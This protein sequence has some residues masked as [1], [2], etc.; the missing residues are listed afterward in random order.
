M[1]KLRFM[2]MIFN[3]ADGSLVMH[4]K[5]FIQPAF[6]RLGITRLKLEQFDSLNKFII[7]YY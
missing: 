1:K 6:E 5:C 7:N 2:V 4:F 3:M